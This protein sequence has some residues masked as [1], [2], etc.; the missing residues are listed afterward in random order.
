M[1]DVQVVD[2]HTGGEPTRVVLAGGPDL[3]GG[4]LAERRARFD[5]AHGAWR[6]AV[7]REPRGHAAMVG[8]LLLPPD[9]PAAAAGVLF[10]NDVGTLGM[11]GH[12][13]IGLLV[14]LHHLGHLALGEHRIDT[15]VGPVG[16]TLLDARTVEIANV[17]AYRH[18][19]GVALDVPGYGRVVGDVAWGGNWFFLVHG[20]RR[21]LRLDTVAALTA[22]ASAIRDALE[23]AGVTGADGAV[24][25][26]VE[27]IG[28]TAS[29]DARSFVLCPGGAYDR[30]P[31]GTGTSAHL[32]CL[33]AEGRL[34]PGRVWRQESVVGSRFEAWIDAVDGAQVRPRLRGQAFVTGEARLRFH[35]DDPFRFG[36][37]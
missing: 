12:G 16:A 5:A 1:T 9:D 19:A 27:L 34:T 17:P 30:S 28:P 24:I 18:R 2:S 33:H 32:A 23:A 31:C 8:A 25:D 29:A 26:H 21:D 14:T 11:C 3:G 35:P 20:D 15:P 4:S 10:F 6:D 7:V 37:R 13:T 22:E 36:L